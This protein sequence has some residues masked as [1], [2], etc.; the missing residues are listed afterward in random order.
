[1]NKV[2]V[3]TGGSSGIG[4][5]TAR[6]LSQKGYTV[7]EFSRSGR[8]EDLVKHIT[9]DVTDE[10]QVRA[11]FEQ[12][13]SERGR[14]DLLVN[15]AGMGISGAIEFT[16]IQ[17]ARHI[18]DVNFFGVFS[19]IKESLQYLRKTQNSQIINVSSVAAVFSIPY[20]SFYS[21][22]KSAQNS[23]TLALSSELRPFHIRVNAIMPG[24]VHTGFTEARSKNEVGAEF[25]G[26][27]I[28]NAVAVME[29]DEN[30]GMSPEKIAEAI[31]KVS[32]K[33]CTG[34]LFTVGG[35]YKAAV[36]LS[37]FLPV[38]FVTKLIA[39]MYR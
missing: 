2:A 1:M 16:E 24:D 20:Q 22:T 12:V 18:F 38:S 35:K 11:A 37:R 7:F 32:Q 6:L 30:R 33:E 13:F 10:G 25:Y 21:A 29:K 26:D 27:I 9:V 17:E 19:C 5:E 14:L 4:K 28:K 3:V 23:L 36:F 34:K 31:V 8:D 15:N 39:D